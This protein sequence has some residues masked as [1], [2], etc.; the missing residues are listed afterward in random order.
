M[1]VLLSSAL[2]DLTPIC[3]LGPSTDFPGKKSFP[4]VNIV[5]LCIY[6]FQSTVQSLS[7][8]LF[9]P[10]YRECLKRT[11]LRSLS[12][13]TSSKNEVTGSSH[14][15]ISCLLLQTSVS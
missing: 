1:F 9:T 5:F 11:V 15:L 2:F 10:V 7:I 4:A 13:L 3:E 12:M 6:A 14:K 8:L